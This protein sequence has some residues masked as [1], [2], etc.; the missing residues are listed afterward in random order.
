MPVMTNGD[1][2][3]IGLR[4]PLLSSVPNLVHGFTTRIGGV[5]RGPWSTLNLGHGV[6]DDH[7][8]VEEN[9]RRLVSCARLSALFGVSQVHGSNVVVLT[10]ES[11]TETVLSENADA[12]VTRTSGQ[13][14]S[15]RTADCVP[16]LMV[17]PLV[18]V[19]GA[20]HAGWRGLAAGVLQAALVRMVNDLG[21]DPER[22]MAAMGPAI[23]PCCF[24]VGH[25]VAARLASLGSGVVVGGENG[26]QPRADLFTATRSAL[27]AFGLRSTAIDKVGECTCCDERR[28]FSHRRDKGRTGRH[29][30][31]I[32]IQ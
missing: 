12:L 32:A 18:P 30:S 13:A 26:S 22:V 19:I 21:A 20:V 15:V 14:V 27:R 6:G 16:V 31:Y 24:E 25:D 2:E 9:R 17:D 5:S 1:G 4:S 7:S 28:F 29:I 11:H 8:R 10:A 3:V 23:G